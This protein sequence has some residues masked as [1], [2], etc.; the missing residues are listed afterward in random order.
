[1]VDYT[2]R[3][4]KFWP[5]PRVKRL[6]ER[7]GTRELVSRDA[8]NARLQGT[9]PRESDLDPQLLALFASDTVLKPASQERAGD[10]LL[11]E[12]DPAGKILHDYETLNTFA[13]EE[14]LLDETGAFCL[15]DLV[16]LS[17]DQFDINEQFVSNIMAFVND[18]NK[19]SFDKRDALAAVEYVVNKAD[20]DEH[21]VSDLLDAMIVNEL[22]VE[23]H[24]SRDLDQENEA[25]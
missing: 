25:A 19:H 4:S 12:A 20:I 17:E 14:G 21:V 2:D 16:N 10:V 1:M 9:K 5:E 11:F 13:Q 24:L 23:D 8:D 15:E 22:E 18:E 3:I 6:Y 7:F